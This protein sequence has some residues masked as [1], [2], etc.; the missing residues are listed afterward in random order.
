MNNRRNRRSFRPSFDQMPSRIAPSGGIAPPDGFAPMGGIA[1]PPPPLSSALSPEIPGL[2]GPY[3]P[4][5]PIDPLAPLVPT[6]VDTGVR[7]G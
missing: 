1:F 3:D 7:L 5:A 6:S 2:N 4:T